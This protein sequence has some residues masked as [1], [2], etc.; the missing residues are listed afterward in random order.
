MKTVL[1]NKCMVD[2]MTKLKNYSLNMGLVNLLS[3]LFLTS[4]FSI[5]EKVSF[6]SIEII[7]L[8]RDLI[9]QLILLYSK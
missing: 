1:V 3:T 5:N 7:N 9:W 6:N 2:I 8:Q 4:I